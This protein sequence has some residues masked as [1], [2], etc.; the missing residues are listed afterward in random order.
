M[1][2]VGCHVGKL[3]EFR[4]GLG[5]FPR[6]IRQF[7]FLVF[8]LRNVRLNSDK[9][10]E[11]VLVVLHRRDIEFIPKKTAVL[12]VI[13]EFRFGLGALQDGL[14][15]GVEPGL[16]MIRPLEE[17][18]ILAEHFLLGV[19]RDFFKRG[20]TIDRGQVG[21]TGIGNEDAVRGRIDRAIA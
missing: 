4:V 20:V 1:Q 7:D 3:L 16:M 21:L 5:Q 11:L 18:T 6:L 13:A 17:T 8:A 14:A 10:R 19:A 12:A 15:Y 2:V 9:M